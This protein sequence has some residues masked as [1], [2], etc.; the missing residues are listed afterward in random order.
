MGYSYEDERQEK[1]KYK[2]RVRRET[3]WQRKIAQKVH[4]RSILIDS[5]TLPQWK[6]YRKYIIPPQR[7]N[8]IFTIFS[9]IEMVNKIR[10]NLSN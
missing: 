10:T 8:V 5:K 9:L 6:N 7:Q 4:E 3:I 2:Q 1:G